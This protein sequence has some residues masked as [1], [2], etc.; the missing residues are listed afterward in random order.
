MK[1][2]EAQALG[3]R[4]AVLT[5]AGKMRQAYTLLAPILAQRTPFPILGRI[6]AT[7]G[8]GPLQEV[9]AFLE[10]IAA[11]RA[12]G[13]WV[14]IGTALGAQ[15]DRD[16]GGAFDRCRRFVVRA[17][18][19]YGAD[20]LGERVPGPALCLEFPPALDLLGPW[21]EDASRWVRRTLGVAVHFWARRSRGAA[22]HVPQAQA[23]LAF[24][25]PLFSEWDM[26]AVK[27]VG[28]G[29]KTLGRHF[30][31]PVA[32]WLEEQVVVRKRRHRALMLRKALTYLSEEQR[33]R[34][35]GESS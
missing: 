21:R 1:A 23:L 16:M 14:V 3:E 30:P 10:Q 26:D 20:I 35:T 2:Q 18:V 19:W 4:I 13:G 15:L 31:D 9:N 8:R 22:S 24:L 5:E 33:A 25:E 27:G 29:L 28:W 32:A 11:D 7:V 34:A 17:D 6:G 12:E